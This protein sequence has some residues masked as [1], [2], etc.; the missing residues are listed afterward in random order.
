MVVVLKSPTAGMVPGSDEWKNL[1]AETLNAST[2][3]HIGHVVQAMKFFS[4]TLSGKAHVHD[5]DKLTDHRTFHADFATW[6]ET[7]PSKNRHHITTEGGC[8][9]DVNLLD[10]LEHIADCATAGTARS[11]KDKVYKPT[12]SPELLMKAFENT[13]TLLLGEIVEIPE[14]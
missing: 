13:V 9:D 12:V 11:G 2:R 10:V 14:L 1:P 8:P 4:D 3:E 5:F 7:H 6:F